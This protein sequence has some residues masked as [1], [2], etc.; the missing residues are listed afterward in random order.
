MPPVACAVCV[1]LYI[2]IFVWA[3]TRR[4]VITNEPEADVA[5]VRV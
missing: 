2:L 3:Y 5:A 1:G 4:D